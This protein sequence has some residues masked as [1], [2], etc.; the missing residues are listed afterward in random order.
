M[1]GNKYMTKT[2]TPLINSYDNWS[3]LEE[4][5]LGD[6]YPCSWY[7]HL[8]G[9][10]RDCFHELTERT[11][12]DLKIIETKLESLGVTVRRPRYDCI[13][14]YIE[15]DT[16]QLAKPE[17]CPRDNYVTIGQTL[18]AKPLGGR[19]TPWQQ[20]IDTYESNGDLV[21][22]VLANN[23]MGLNGAT[24]VRAGK[25]LYF[26]LYFQQDN[27]TQDQKSILIDSF[28]QDFAHKFKDY[29]IHILFNGGHVDACFALLKPGT[30]LGSR[31]FQ[32]YD[33]TFPG[34]QLINVSQPEFINHAPRSVRA[35]LPGQNGKW[36][37]P[38]F[39]Y[40]KAFN[41]HVIEHAQTWIGDY[42]ETFFEVNCL[43]VDEHNVVIPGENESVFRNL[44]IMG[45]TAHSVPFRTR[46]F[47]DGGMHCIT[48]DIRRRGTCQDFFPDREQP[49]I[50]VYNTSC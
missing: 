18:F 10:V 15:H 17:I 26:D 14:D 32:D 43:V 50:M 2:D 20:H 41:N 7:D 1:G 46:T 5:W 48:L 19:I 40:S 8:P 37:L 44:E 4:V 35:G 31:Y 34:W 27:P 24:I 6:V 42:T 12:Q 47:W 28:Q 22:H 39:G 25:D 9:E 38:G 36:W 16:Q 33:Q 45:I 13:D 49:N 23:I 29:R 3:S 21:D 11:Q 30:I